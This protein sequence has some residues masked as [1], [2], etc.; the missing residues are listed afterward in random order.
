MSLE[1]CIDGASQ[2]RIKGDAP[3]NGSRLVISDSIAS[4]FFPT[5]SSGTYDVVNNDGL[6]AWRIKKVN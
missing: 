3:T 5:I 1:M 2:I 6:S 4:Q